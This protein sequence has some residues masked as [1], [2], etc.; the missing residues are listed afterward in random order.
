MKT[1]SRTTRVTLSI[2]PRC[3]EMLP[4]ISKHA[5]GNH[6]RT[7]P[8]LTDR[9]QLAQSGG[10]VDCLAEYVATIDTVEIQ[11]VWVRSPILPFMEVAEDFY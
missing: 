8:L 5:A 2:E 10:H 7:H 11:F 1:P 4:G 9:L 3:S 6:E